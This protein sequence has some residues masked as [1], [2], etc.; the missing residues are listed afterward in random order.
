MIRLRRLDDGKSYIV[1][2]SVAEIILENAN[3]A[4][5]AY[6]LMS[7]LFRVLCLN[8]SVAQTTTL[9]SMKLRHSGDAVGNVIEGAYRVLQETEK[10]LAAPRR[11]G[12]AFSLRRMPGSLTRPF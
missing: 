12:P 5:S 8:S 10:V 2:D 9:D 11:T 3:D 7:G 4:A 1:G 6:D